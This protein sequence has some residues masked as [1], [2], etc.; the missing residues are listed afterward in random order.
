MKQAINIK[1]L[2][3]DSR[4]FTVEG[5][6]WNADVVKGKSIRIF[7]TGENKKRLPLAVFFSRNRRPMSEVDAHN[8]TESQ[9]I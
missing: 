6:S 2:E 3:T 9:C 1:G 4:V 5:D 7:G 8:A